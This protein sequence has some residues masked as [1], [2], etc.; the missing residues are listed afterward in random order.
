MQYRY[1]DVLYKLKKNTYLNVQLGPKVL[2]SKSNSFHLFFGVV[3][4]ITRKDR[5]AFC[6]LNRPLSVFRYFSVYVSAEISCLLSG[7]SGDCPIT[8]YMH[9]AVALSLPDKTQKSQTRA[10]RIGLSLSRE[11]KAYFSAA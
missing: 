6:S 7:S 11:Y 5:N 1:I 2:N 9:A 8:R 3:Y 4:P 10:D